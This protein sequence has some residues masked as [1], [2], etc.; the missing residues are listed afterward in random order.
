MTY[1]IIGILALIIL[2]ITNRD[3]LWQDH[4]SSRH[5]RDYRLF[6]IG[7]MAYYITDLLWGILEEHWMM[8][9]LYAD[10]AVHFAAMAAAVMLWTQYVISYLGGESGFEKMLRY[11]GRIFLGFV[12]TVIIINFFTPLLFWFDETGGYHADVLRFVILGIQI[13]LFLLTSAYTLCVTVRSEGTI[14]LC[15]FYDRHVRYR[16]DTADCNPGSLSADAILCHG[17]YAGNMRAAQLCCGG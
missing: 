6:L 4:H 17:I 5:Q 1:S 11:A 3:I 8:T 2:L 16:H 13:L 9:A 14:K 12:M 7:V 10:T 15:H